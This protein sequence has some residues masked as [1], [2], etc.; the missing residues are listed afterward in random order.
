MT[1]FAAQA[2]RKRRLAVSLLFIAPA[3]WSVNYIVAR[4]APGEVAPHALALGRWLMAFLIMLPFAWQAIPAEFKQDR[5]QFFAAVKKEGSDLLILGALGMWICGAF[6]YLGAVTTS[7]INIGL[8]YSVSPALLAIVSVWWFKEHLRASQW[9]GVA[10]AVC[11]VLFVLFKGNLQN[12]TALEFTSG[13][14]WIVIAALSWTVYSILLRR[15]LSVFDPFTRLTLITGAGVLVLIP[16]TI[17]EVIW[18]NPPA[19]SSYSILLMLAVAVFPGVCAYQ[20]YSFMQKELGAARTG[21]VLY[22]GPLYA[23]ASAW[24]FLGEPP[25]WYH[26]VAAPMILFGVYWVS[27]K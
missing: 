8:I 24:I 5:G 3:L 22:L 23:A 16:F 26:F 12:L 9:L 18:L 14:W 21:L 6:V 25:Q 27:R 4:K 20:A 11:G 10:C 19:L 2:R 15:R 1:A 7:A 17:G 13:D